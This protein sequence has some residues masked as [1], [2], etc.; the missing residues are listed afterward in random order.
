MKQYAPGSQGIDVLEFAASLQTLNAHPESL[1]PTASAWE[2]HYE[3][4]AYEIKRETNIKFHKT[5]AD[6]GHKLKKHLPIK[7]AE[8]LKAVYA[9][10]ESAPENLESEGHYI[11]PIPKPKDEHSNTKLH[12]ES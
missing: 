8:Q 10:L 12:G 2:K 1:P 3:Q 5:R 6:L 4:R 11:F 7:N 9:L